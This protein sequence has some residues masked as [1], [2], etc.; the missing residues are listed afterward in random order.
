MLIMYDETAI[1]LYENCQCID[2]AS[3]RIYRSKFDVLCWKFDVFCCY[4][5]QYILDIIL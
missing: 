5:Y 3:A 1:D 4:A 2:Y